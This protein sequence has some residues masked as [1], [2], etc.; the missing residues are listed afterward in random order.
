M[1]A[2]ATHHFF[3]QMAD[4]GELRFARFQQLSATI[5][6]ISPNAAADRDPVGGEKYR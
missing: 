2:P 1:A 6:R 5:A 4:F 3:G